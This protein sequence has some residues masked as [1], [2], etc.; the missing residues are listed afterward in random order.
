MAGLK[1]CVFAAFS[2]FDRPLGFSQTFRGVASYWLAWRPEFSQLFRRLIAPRVFADFSRR[3]YI[4][5]V[6]G[7]LRI[8]PDERR[9]FGI[10]GFRVP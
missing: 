3:G 4:E 1:L 9:F 2:T 8:V 6:R 7:P 10:A 5:I